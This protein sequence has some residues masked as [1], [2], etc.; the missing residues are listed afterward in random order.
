MP[1]A[2]IPFENLNP[3]S[4]E[5]G[6]DLLRV[7]NLLPL[8]GG[9]RSIPEPQTQLSPILLNEPITGMFIH[10]WTSG[11]GTTSYLGDVAIEFYGTGTKLYDQSGNDLSR[12]G[13]YGGG[14]TSPSGWR[15]CSFGNDVVMTNWYDPVQFRAANT[16]NFAD[17]FTST[18]KPRARF[19]CVARG[20]L[21]LADINDPAGAYTF[22]D[23]YAWSDINDE[24]NLDPA[25]TSALSNAGKGRILSRPGQIMGMVGGEYV[26][27]WKRHSMHLLQ[28]TGVASDPWRL[29][30]ICNGVGTHHPR[31]IVEGKDGYVYFFGGD[32]FYR[33]AGSSLPEKI[34]EDSLSSYLCDRQFGG[35]LGDKTLARASISKMIDEDRRMCS[36][37]S[38]RTGLIFWFYLPYNIAACVGICYNPQTGQ[39]STLSIGSGGY[40]VDA[41]CNGGSAAYNSD[42]IL[43]D[44]VFTH[45]SL[46]GLDGVRSKFISST[47]GQST[48]RTQRQTI[49][50]DESNKPVTVRINRVLP[51]ASTAPG[52]NTPPDLIALPS[53]T[54]INI[55]GSNDPYWVAISDDIGQISPRLVT[56]TLASQDINGGFLPARIEAKSILCELY[57]PSGSVPVRGLKGI[58][59]DYEVVQ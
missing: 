56:T 4:G 20:Q 52:S 7:E 58:Y 1:L 44:V 21:F 25:P 10:H 55:Y 36:V 9:W 15:G 18:F 42:N 17:C 28:Y 5:H 32:G 19:C 48:I 54:Q 51:I 47:Y 23:A 34:M 31:S 8:W 57:I 43:D 46:N 38:S 41:S 49:A 45:N 39:S 30:E 2:F 53:A 12:G 6:N 37:L 59:L 24:R 26:R 13:G 29:D 22:Q 3:G 33:Q 27:F 50:W 14:A 11:A 40:P 16:G 35:G